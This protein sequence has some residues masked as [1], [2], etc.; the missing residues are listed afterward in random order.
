MKMPYT[1]HKWGVYIKEWF[2]DKIQYGIP[3]DTVL[4]V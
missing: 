3:E 2:Q 1:F 4:K